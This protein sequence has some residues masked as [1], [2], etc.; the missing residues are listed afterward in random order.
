[1]SALANAATINDQEW[2]Y[3][4]YGVSYDPVSVVGTHFDPHK[5]VKGTEDIN[6]WLATQL[7]PHINI[8]F[9]EG[10]Y[11]GKAKVVIAKI[12]QSLVYPTK[13]KNK[14]FI[15][16]GQSKKSLEDHPEKQKVLWTKLSLNDFESQ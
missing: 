14:V 3:L 1:M 10:H 2:G 15:R 5:K 13:F 12:E 6:N 11:Q 9:I 7:D 16:V 4:V 8:T